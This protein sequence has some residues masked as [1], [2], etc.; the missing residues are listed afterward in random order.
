M[1]Y[2]NL[3]KIINGFFLNQIVTLAIFAAAM[4]SLTLKPAKSKV[5]N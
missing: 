1:A 2:E 3:L 5:K 4:L